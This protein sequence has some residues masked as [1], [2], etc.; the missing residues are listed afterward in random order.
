MKRPN[1][2]DISSG[3]DFDN[4]YWGKD[5]LAQL[6]EMLGLPIS[7]TK[8]ELRE[9]IKYALDNLGEHKPKEPKKSKFDWANEELTIETVITDNVTFNDNFRIFMRSHIGDQFTCNYD[10]MNWVRDNEGKTL[11]D[12]I[13]K[14]HAIKAQKSDPHYQS[15]P[16][17][18]FRKYVKDF[19]ADNKKSNKEEAQKY[20]RERIQH[21]APEG[22]VEYSKEDL[23]LKVG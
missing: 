10:F 19:L 13:M 3:A 18:L 2:T 8:A 20:W 9:R 22:K 21:P 23:N 11:G 15:S 16:N 4:W 5:E 6:C 12:A 14:W 17:S 1:F 7:G